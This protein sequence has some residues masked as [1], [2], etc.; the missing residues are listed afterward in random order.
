MRPTRDLAK[1]RGEATAYLGRLRDQTSG[2]IADTTPNSR[3]VFAHVTIELLNTWALF[4]RC[5]F[6]SC[7]IRPRRVNGGRVIA[8]AFSGNDFSDAIGVAMARHRQRRAPLPGGGWDRRDE[9]TWHDT[10]VLLS[11]CADLGCS[12]LA[13]IQAALSTG[14]AV[15]YHLPTFRNFFAHRND[16]TA[17]SARNVAAFYSIPTAGRHPAE[18]LR[19]RP[20]G[21]PFPILLEWIDDIDVT[22]ELLCE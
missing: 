15:F 14:T 4:A 18:I 9:P 7:V 21:R 16:S 2:V 1:L 3:R 6:L 17:Q 12:N 5:F 10:A 8:T 22:V 13:Q 11:S 19:Q 20:H